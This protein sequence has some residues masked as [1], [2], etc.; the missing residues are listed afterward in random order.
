MAPERSLDPDLC[1]APGFTSSLTLP[2]CVSLHLLPLGGTVVFPSAQ[3]L[4]LAFTPFIAPVAH[5]CG[6]KMLKLEQG[7]MK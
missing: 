1:S 3:S 6:G 4:Q 2:F 5:L 7:N